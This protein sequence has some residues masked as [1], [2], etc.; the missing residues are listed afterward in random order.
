MTIP[1]SHRVAWIGVGGNLGNALRVCGRAVER[2]GDHAGVRL[3]ARSR[4][5]RTEP[6]GPVRH[7]PWYVNGVVGVE[8]WY[9]PHA[10]LRILARI[11]TSFGRERGGELRWGPRPLDLDLLLHG[12][13]VLRSTDLILPHPRL[14]L[15]R[16]V[17]Q[18]LWE[19]A[20][21]LVHPVFGKTVD[22][23]LREVDDTGQ[24]IPWSDGR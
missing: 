6:V 8:T 4:F 11:E 16:F 20:P 24:A 12:N 10:L 22:T 1:S 18:P 2:L 17:L 21:A 15:R 5:Y 7:Q 13:R 3:V 23:M 19:V 9:G 14:H